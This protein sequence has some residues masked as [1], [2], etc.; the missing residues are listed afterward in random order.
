MLDVFLQWCEKKF[1]FIQQV[2]DGTLM[3]WL[4]PSQA[5]RSSEFVGITNRIMGEELLTGT[6]WLRGSP[7]HTHYTQWLMKAAS[8]KSLAQLAVSS[9]GKCSKEK[10]RDKQAVVSQMPCSWS[11]RW[12]WANMWLLESEFQSSARAASAVWHWIFSRRQKIFW[13]WGHSIYMVLMQKSRCTHIQI[14]LQ[15]N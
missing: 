2:T 12:L 10:W 15:I 5:W 11:P 14:N 8:M 1:L 7:P 4:H 13:P 6:W 3:R 9:I